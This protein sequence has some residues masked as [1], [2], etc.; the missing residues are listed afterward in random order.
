[1]NVKH[2]L[3]KGVYFLVLR[4]ISSSQY[5]IRLDCVVLTSRFDLSKAMGKETTSNYI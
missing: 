3:K 4:D 1:M 2:S 5:M